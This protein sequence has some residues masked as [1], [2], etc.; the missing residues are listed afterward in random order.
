MDFYEYM[1]QLPSP[2]NKVIEE[3]AERCR[4]TNTSVYRWAQ[5]TA[6]PSA[7]Y[8]S[9]I[10]EVLNFPETELFPGY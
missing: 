6:K 5:G 10:A 8:R 2:R 1:K 3:I 9:I 7:I 4:V